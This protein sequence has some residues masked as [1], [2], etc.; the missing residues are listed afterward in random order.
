MEGEPLLF[1][2]S[3]AGYHVWGRS[4]PGSKMCGRIIVIKSLGH[5]LPG[6]KKASHKNGFLMTRGE[7]LIYKEL[8]PQPSGKPHSVHQSEEGYRK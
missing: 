1:G 4:T 8:C 6:R 2:R 3:F 7:Q 5:C